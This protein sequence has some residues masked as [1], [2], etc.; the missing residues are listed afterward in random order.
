VGARASRSRRGAAEIDQDRASVTAA[1]IDQDGSGRAVRNGSRAGSNQSRT[2]AIRAED[3]DRSKIP[4][5]RIEEDVQIEHETRPGGESFA[6]PDGNRLGSFTRPDGN[7]LGRDS[8][9]D[10]T[11]RQEAGTDGGGGC[12]EKS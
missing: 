11:R 12:E 6:R 2:G 10:R 7:R 5:G 1:E 8:G 3:G 9:G 4:R